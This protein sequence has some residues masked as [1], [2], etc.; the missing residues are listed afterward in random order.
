MS[1]PAPD[2]LEPS[3]QDDCELNGHVFEGYDTFTEMCSY[4]G[5]VRERLRRAVQRTP[6]DD[7]HVCWTAGDHAFG[8]EGICI[9]CGKAEVGLAS[10]DRQLHAARHAR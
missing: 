9:H 8:S 5:T 1:S 7:I 2:A 10:A 3:P 4:C 6:A